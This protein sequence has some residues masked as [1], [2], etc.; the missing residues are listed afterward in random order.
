[1][2]HEGNGETVA[3]IPIKT[4]KLIFP[5]TLEHSLVFKKQVCTQLV[6]GCLAVFLSQAGSGPKEVKNGSQYYFRSVLGCRT[7]LQYLQRKAELNV[8]GL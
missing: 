6:I 4:V 5:V 7:F 3:V 8:L 2:K 1:M